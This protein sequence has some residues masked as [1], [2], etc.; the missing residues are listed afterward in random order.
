MFLVVFGGE[1][2]DNGGADI[3]SVAAGSA[4]FMDFTPLQL[5]EVTLEEDIAVGR[6]VVGKCCWALKTESTVKK[7]LMMM[8]TIFFLAI[9]AVIF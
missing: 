2:V 8:T 5:G 3:V 6:G 4:A 7:Q 9:W 1:G